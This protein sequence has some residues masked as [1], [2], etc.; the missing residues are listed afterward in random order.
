MLENPS[1]QILIIILV[2]RYPFC[3]TS[4]D[5]FDLTLTECPFYD[6]P[7]T[8][9]VQM[10]IEFIYIFILMKKNSN[11]QSCTRL[12]IYIILGCFYFALELLI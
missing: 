11:V 2:K 10:V 5:R 3:D 12:S 1:F 7:P 9:F 4:R 8:L 6:F